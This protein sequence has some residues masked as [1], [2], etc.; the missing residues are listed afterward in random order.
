DDIRRAVFAE[1]PDTVFVTITKAAAA[2]VNDLAVS[3]FFPDQEMDY[4]NGMGATILGL[5]QGGVRV[6]TDTGF[7][8][9][10][11]PWTD[12]ESRSTYHPMRLG[13]ANTLTKLQGATLDS[14]TLYLDV[15]NIP[16]AGYVALSRVRYDTHWRFVGY[17]T[18]HHFTP[19]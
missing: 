4:V 12:A 1:D 18:Q 19:A 13:Y 17:L 9:V 3:T 7:I 8:V 11:Y 14:M 16:A 10:V 2:A 6:R 5:Q 15:P